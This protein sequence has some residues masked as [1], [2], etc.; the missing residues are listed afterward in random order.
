MNGSNPPVRHHFSPIF[1]LKRWAGGDDRLEQFS[2]PGGAGRGIRA[3]RLPPSATGYADNL[4]AMPGLPDHL[5]QQVEERFMQVLD[6]KAAKILQRLE[7]GGRIEWDS[8]MRSGWAR[9]VLSLQLRTPADIVGIKGASHL[10][11]GRDGPE[12]PIRL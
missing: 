7:A 3:R 12:D 9:F 6:D 10:R 5:V 1:Y 8:A 2:R 4:Y 11:V